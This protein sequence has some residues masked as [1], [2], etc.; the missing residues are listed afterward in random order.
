MAFNIEITNL[1]EVLKDFE[2]YGEKAEDAVWFGMLRT[3]TQVKDHAVF[4]VHKITSTLA[5][6]IQITDEDRE[7]LSITVSTNVEYAAAEEFGFTGTQNVSAHTREMTQAFGRPFRKTVNVRS[8]TR[9]VS[10]PPHPYM[11]PAA[12]LG[13]RSIGPNVNAELEALEL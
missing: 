1:N 4:T 2:Q 11:L 10:R 3:A 13:R 8:H 5:R 7:G 9:Y 6:S 12:E